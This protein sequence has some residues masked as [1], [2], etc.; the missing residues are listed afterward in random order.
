MTRF[1]RFH[2]TG[3]PEVLRIEEEPQPVPGSGE[4]LLK[5][6]AIG[7]NRAEAAQRGGHYIVKPELPA[8]LGGEASGRI[9]AVGPGVA[10]WRVG[11]RVS[12]LPLRQKG[13]YGV[14]ATEALWP[15]AELMPHPDG[16]DPVQSAALWLA[17][18]TAWGGLIETGGLGKGD[19]VLITAGSSSVGLAALQVARDAGAVAIGTTRGSA[20]ADAL[21]AAGAQ[22]VIATD[23]Q[24]VRAEVARLTAGKGVR[25]VFDPVAGPFAERLFE[26]LAPEGT[27]MI[28][29]G[30]ANQPAVFPRH[31]AIRKG[32]SMRG[33]SVHPL[34]SNAERRERA[35]AAILERVLDG[36]FRMPIARTFTLDEI[37]EAHRTMERNE[38]VGKLVVVPG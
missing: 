2:E 13:D 15:A 26:C 16:V 36:R 6:E 17:F 32:L 3:G 12:V 10:E 11:D 7:L 19:T 4:V 24:D 37:V 9:L 18:F 23:E 20:K 22:H 28:Y 34:L 5:I 33:Y 1:V 27:L 30:L 8:R 38:H 29:G 21:R 14:Y 25:L 31:L 35:H